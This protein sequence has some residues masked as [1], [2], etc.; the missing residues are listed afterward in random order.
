V[1]DIEHGPIEGRHRELG[2]S[3]A[4]FSGW[5]MPLSYAGTVTEHNA[6]RSAVGLF[7]VS[8]LGKAV[9]RG[10]GAAEFVNSALTNDLR[11]I[12]PGKAQYTLCCTESGGVIDDLIAYY[13]SDDEIFLVPNAANTADVVD[14]LKAVAPQGLTITDEHR[15]H[16][17][18]AVQ[19]PKSVSVLRRLGLP[20]DM[21]YMGYADA[22]FADVPVRVC[23]TGYT[24]EHG[25]ELLPPW[26]RAGAVFDALVSEVKQAR[27]EPAG[28]GARDTLRTE[29]GYPLHGHELSRDISPLQARCGWAIGWKKDAFWGRDAL[30]AEKAAG[31]PRLLRG[32]RA[33][34][35]GVLRPELTV[36]DGD[37]PVGVTT[38]G[39]F[40]PTLKVGIA[41]AMIDSAARIDDGR[42]V[43]VDVRGRPLGCDVITPPF[44]EA[45]TR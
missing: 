32:L 29:M 8:H 41:L 19:G 37:T 17:V 40:S 34:G 21:D 15:S 44:V 16:A 30:L 9:V 3:F 2:A 31:P 24:G 38:S 6:T 10:P 42:R 35:R 33:V 45:K 18:F 1:G 4:E 23:R 28:L 5:L 20:T 39:T 12:G 13:V 26:D 25:Y 7:D 27:G 11:R 14:A 22:R 43:T 36:L